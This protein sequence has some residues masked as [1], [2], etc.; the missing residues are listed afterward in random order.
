MDSTFDM[1]HKVCSV[2]KRTTCHKQEFREC[3]T[4]MYIISVQM[5]IACICPQ[6]DGI[7]DRPCWI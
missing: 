5:E 3:P 2:C 1:C 4:L 7:C 6:E